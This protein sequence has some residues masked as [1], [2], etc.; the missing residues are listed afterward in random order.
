M[1]HLALRHWTAI[2]IAVA[3]AA[4]ALFYLPQTPSWMIFNLKQAIDARDGS[5]AARYVDFQQVVR[6]AGYEAVQDH[7]SSSGG[8]GG[9][10]DALIGKGAIDFLSGPIASMLKSWAIQQVDNG[11]KQVQLPLAAAAGAIFLLHR[12]H[13]AA[14]TSWQDHKG[15][16]WE[17]RMARE[18]GGW[19]IVEVKNVEQLLKKLQ[20]NQLNAAPP[21][22]TLPPDARA[23]AQ[24]SAGP[25]DEGLINR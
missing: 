4:W 10:V 5:D 13:D 15:Q 20:E 17:V 25:S 1:A 3:V 16:E 23:G 19:K 8:A 18:D 21:A 22:E 7:D 12:N 14:Y 11:A 9:L 2:L 24:P 6:N